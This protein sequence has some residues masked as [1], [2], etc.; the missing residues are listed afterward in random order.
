MEVEAF[1]KAKK[2]PLIIVLDNVRSMLNV[3]STFRT[4]DAFR[5]EKILLVGITAK[6]PHREINKS[7]LGATESVDWEYFETVSESMDY[8]KNS[9]CEILSVEQAEGSTPLETFQPENNQKY[10]LVFGN[11]VTG[12]SEEFINNSDLCLEIPQFGTKHSLNV[13]VS[14][15]VAIWEIFNKIP[16]L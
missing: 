3:G 8:L 15:G 12:V 4:S 1:K 9:G 14:V 16:R 5:I 6:P 2:T 10:A 7:A 13:S 11:E